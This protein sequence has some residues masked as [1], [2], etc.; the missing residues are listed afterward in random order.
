MEF[1]RYRLPEGD[2]PAP[3]GAVEIGR[4]PPLRSAVGGG[5]QDWMTFDLSGL[6][7]LVIQI[8]GRYDGRRSDDEDLILVAAIGVDAKGD[9]HP[10]GLTTR[11]RGATHGT[12]RHDCNF[13]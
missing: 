1:A 11:R 9:K 8:Y 4:L 7:L 10:L 6:N 2:V 5:M 12:G 3:A 13:G